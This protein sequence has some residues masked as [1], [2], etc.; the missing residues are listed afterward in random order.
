MELAAEQP[1][2]VRTNRV[3]SSRPIIVIAKLSLRMKHRAYEA[4]RIDANSRKGAIAR[5]RLPVPSANST[6]YSPP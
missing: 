6:H 5:T 2:Q 4:E 3:E 1:M